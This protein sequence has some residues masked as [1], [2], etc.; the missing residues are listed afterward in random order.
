MS[1]R[2]HSAHQKNIIRNYYEN[3]DTIMLQRLQELVTDLYLADSDAKR[4]RLWLRV[5]KAMVKLTV[6][7]SM[8]EHILETRSPE[9]LANNIQDWLK[10]ADGVK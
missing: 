8:A 7:A 3:L 2:E 6:P 4:Q 5:E 1:P 9:V 10:K